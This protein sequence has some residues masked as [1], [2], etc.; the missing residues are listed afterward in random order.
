VTRERQRDEPA[1]AAERMTSRDAGRAKPL[2]TI[3]RLLEMIRFS[4][5]LFA[6]PFAILAAMVAWNVPG[7]DGA[8]VPFRLMHLIGILVCMVGAR[9]AAMAFNRLVD[10]RWDAANPRTA[11]RHLPAGTLSVGTVVLFTLVSIAIFFAGTAFFLPNVVP[12]IAAAPVL[13]WLLGYS[14]AKRFTSLAHF[15]LGIALGLSPL[16]AW[17][18][19]RGEWLLSH[20]TDLLPAATISIAVL[21]WVAGFDIIYACQDRDYD[22]TAGLRSVPVRLGIAGALRAAA[23]CHALMIAVLALLPWVETWGGPPLGLGPIYVAGLIGIAILLVVEHA[24]VRPHDL[25]RVNVAF[26][27]VNVAVALALLAIVAADL[28]W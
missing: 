14:Y 5:S 20:P 26:F 11:G 22:A 24:L 4:H 10:R 16:A 27:Q 18:A 3:R 12:L 17:L 25:A 9:S 2:E 23:V 1:E 8:A 15:W 6:L 19:L 21:L 28:I 7:P 13:A